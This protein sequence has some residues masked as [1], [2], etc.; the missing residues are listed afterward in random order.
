MNTPLPLYN[1]TVG[2]TNVG[3][4]FVAVAPGI[5]M[6]MV[7]Y[8][9]VPDLEHALEIAGTAILT[10]LLPPRQAPE[11]PTPNPPTKPPRPA[12]KRTKQ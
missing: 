9:E 2:P 5:G 8:T 6:P 1:I 4:W 3:H 10:D 12:K 11:S 7:S